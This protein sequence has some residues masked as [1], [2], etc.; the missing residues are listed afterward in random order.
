MKRGIKIFLCVVLAYGVVTYLFYLDRPRR[1]IDA[2][3]KMEQY[4]P[5]VQEFVVNNMDLMNEV[6]T[7]LD[8]NDPDAYITSGNMGSEVRINP[9]HHGES[10][11]L[12]DWTGLTPEERETVISLFTKPDAPFGSYSSKQYFI[13]A[14]SVVGDWVDL[15]LTRYTDGSFE[16]WS[17]APYF[18]EVATNWYA[19]PVI[20]MGIDLTAYKAERKLSYPR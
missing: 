7:I 20:N 10:Y 6:Q 15:R 5:A 3:E 13:K 2:A 12:A 9:E 19:Y 1:M 18:E 4:I 17:N 16:D 11:A 8:E 14:D